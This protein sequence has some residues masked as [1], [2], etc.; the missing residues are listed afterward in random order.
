MSCWLTHIS[1][2]DVT[3]PGGRN[4]LGG[5]IFPRKNANWISFRSQPRGNSNLCS[6]LTIASP[7]VGCD[8]VRTG[9]ESHNEVKAEKAA[10][11]PPGNLRRAQQQI[12]KARS[13]EE[14]Y[15]MA[16]RRQ[17]LSGGPP[18]NNLLEN[19]WPWQFHA[20]SLSILTMRGG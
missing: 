3:H 20:I 5:Q 15:L 6:A 11:S 4:G 12:K 16:L 7:G 18:A 1:V 9:M 19:L 10:C 8:V 17:V 13:E 2:F 14:W